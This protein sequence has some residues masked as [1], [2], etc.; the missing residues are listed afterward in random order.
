MQRAYYYDNINNFCRESPDKILGKITKNNEFALEKKQ[1]NT[2]IYEI[3]LL[4]FCLSEFNEGGVAFEYTI[5]R[6][7]DRIDAV[8]IYSGIIYLLE[9]KV[10]ETNYPSHAIEQVIDYSLDLKYFHKESHNRK[11]VPILICTRAQ[12]INNEITQ[13]SDGIYSVIKA[14]EKTLR[15]ELKLWELALIFFMIMKQTQNC[16]ISVMISLKIRIY[17]KK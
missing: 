9:F 15:P 12:D 8:F 5:P 16:K 1:R 17:W 4:Q 3:S 13:D 11:I 6:I 2:W 14:N 7:G 10:G